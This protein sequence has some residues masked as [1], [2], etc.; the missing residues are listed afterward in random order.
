MTEKKVIEKLEIEFAQSE[1]DWINFTVKLGQR[2]YDAYFTAV[3]DPISDFKFWLEEIALGGENCVFSWEGEG[4]SFSFEFKR[5]GK[6]L[7]IFTAG[8]YDEGDIS[9]CVDRRELLA[10]L[11]R[12]FISFGYSH[13]YM[14]MNYQRMDMWEILTTAIG[15]EYPALIETLADFDRDALTRFFS[16]ARPKLRLAIC[17]SNQHYRWADWGFRLDSDLGTRQR[18]PGWHKAGL[19]LIWNVPANFEKWDRLARLDLAEYSITATSHNYP[20]GVRLS[21]VLNSRIVEDFLEKSAGEPEDDNLDDDE[22]LLA[23]CVTENDF[24]N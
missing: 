23:P 4:P 7:G 24:D 6:H 22:I 17:Y 3:F 5:T 21:R 11:Y 9:G 13:K 16:E 10:T 20:D 18:V 12:G 8:R 19:P 2:S 15:I 14:W 1:F